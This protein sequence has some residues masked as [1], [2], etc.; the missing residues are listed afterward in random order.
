[1]A[2]AVLP[3]EERAYL[4]VMMRRQMNSAVHR[5]MN[6]LLLLDDAWPIERIA[7]ALFIDAETVRQCRRLHLAG[8]IK[9]VET[10]HYQAPDPA[11]SQA[12]CAALEAELGRHLYMTAKAVCHFFANAFAS[13]IPRTRCGVVSGT[14]Q[15]RMRRGAL[16]RCEN[17]DEIRLEPFKGLCVPEALDTMPGEFKRRLEEGSL[18]SGCRCGDCD[19]P[20]RTWPKTGMDAPGTLGVRQDVLRYGLP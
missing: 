9:G 2:G 14:W 10:L 19:V 12:Q 16:G 7:E 15:V 17:V 13:N 3:P 4:P 8:G 20:T 18:I 11:L 6:V 1:M 5:R